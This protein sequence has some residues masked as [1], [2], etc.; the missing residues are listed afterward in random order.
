[1][2]GILIVALIIYMFNDF[3]EQHM[4]VENLI[5]LHV[6]ANSD[7]PV[8]QQLKLSVKDRIVS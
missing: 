4:M 2:L 5:R 7:E 3:R 6:V 8:D 1:M